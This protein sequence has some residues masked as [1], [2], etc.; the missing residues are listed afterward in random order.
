MDKLLAKGA[1]EPLSIGGMDKLLA[2]GANEPSI[3]GAG[4]YYNFFVV[5][6]HTGGLQH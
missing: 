3:H 6:K 4:F 2:K 1:N 5:P